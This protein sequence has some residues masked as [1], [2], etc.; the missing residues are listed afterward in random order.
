MVTYTVF[1]SEAQ[2]AYCITTPS[3][4]KV[5]DYIIDPRDGHKVMV[6]RI[7]GKARL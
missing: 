5:G 3:Y 4:H 7:E 6:A 1:D 2:C